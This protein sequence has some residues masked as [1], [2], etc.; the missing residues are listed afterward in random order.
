MPGNP[1][2]I[3]SKVGAYG[4][5]RITAASTRSDGIGTIG[6]DTFLAFTAD[7]TN[8]SFVQRV[9]FLPTSNA[10]AGNTTT[11]TVGR[12]F[13]CNNS[14]TTNNSTTTIF[15]EVALPSVSVGNATV[16][17]YPVDVP[18]NMALPPGFVIL[19]TSHTA[20]ANANLGYIASVIAGNY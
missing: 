20:Q 5:V 4:G 9:R 6:T 12:V 8:G 10:A 3:Y 16:A 15:Q 17:T 7:A 18:M 19:V 13:I 11:A 1:T 2:P 14:S